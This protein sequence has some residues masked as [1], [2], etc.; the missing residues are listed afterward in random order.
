MNFMEQLETS[1][2]FHENV[3]YNNFHEDEIEV[4]VTEDQNLNN[5]TMEDQNLEHEISVMK[6][7]EVDAFIRHEIKEMVFKKVI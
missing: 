7:Q 2:E 3:N 4:E 5:E 6:Y 1:L